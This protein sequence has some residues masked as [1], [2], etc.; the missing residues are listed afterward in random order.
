MKRIS[1]TFIFLLTAYMVFILL[2]F[3]ITLVSAHRQSN[4]GVL[5]NMAGRQ[6][7]LSQRITK[8]LF[9]YL[10]TGEPEHVQSH[11]NLRRVFETSLNAL[12]D[13]GDIP[14]DLNGALLRTIPGSL[15]DEI[16]QAFASGTEKWQLYVA[17][18]DQIITSYEA[19]ASSGIDSRLLA[20]LSQLSV[21]ILMDMNTTVVLM[22][23]GNEQ[24]VSL[25]LRWQF[26][27]LLI[28]GGY[29]VVLLLIIQRRIAA[30]LLRVTKNAETLSKG[31][32]TDTVD[33]QK[34]S[35]EIGQLQQSF[36]RLAHMLADRISILERIG[37][38][39]LNNRIE[40]SGS[41]DA[42]GSSLSAAQSSLVELISQVQDASGQ[43]RISADELAHS[44]DILA[45]GASDQA[46]SIEQISASLNEILNQTDSTRE[47]VLSVVE[48]SGQSETM[49]KENNV[50]FDQLMGDMGLLEASSGE[51]SSIVKT[52]DDIA[53]QIN[54]LALNANV[55]AARA[56]KYG[57]GFAVV[58]DEVRNLA[59]RS[60]QAVKSTGELI[61]KNNRLTAQL[62]KGIQSNA[63][64]L[65]AIS[66]ASQQVSKLMNDLQQLTGEQ[67]T[68]IREISSALDQISD[69][70]QSNTASAEQ[71]SASAAEL[72]AQ[73]EHL[74]SL[75]GKFTLNN[76]RH[77][78]QSRGDSARIT[79]Q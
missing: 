14:L 34:R 71:V 24:K 13:G 69:I 78:A 27:I 8:D 3:A 77:V 59:G 25:L 33:V 7:M 74:G 29:S 37:G 79:G 10:L 17:E 43:S 38:G 35:D 19:S 54:L 40:G 44:S 57:K 55:E 12:R 52:I 73:N 4:D 16:H 62:R 22:Q 46:A 39:L 47:A 58:A 53:F 23:Q 41:E 48:T 11:R 31:Q 75:V 63:D 64:S 70:I 49:V 1:S 56:G 72:R 18:A 66:Q 61:D 60:A 50:R 2:T 15:T 6:R 36:A 32:P 65:Q 20:E 51:I 21:S 76:S 26:G 30:P 28:A 68:S 5:I 9:L 67:R 42:F 45:A